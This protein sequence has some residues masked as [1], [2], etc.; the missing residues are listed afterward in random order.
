MNALDECKKFVGKFVR[1]RSDRLT[2]T[3]PSPD[4]INMYAERIVSDRERIPKIRCRYFDRTG[5]YLFFDLSPT[6]LEIIPG[7]PA[8][9]DLGGLSIGDLKKMYVGKKACWK[10]GSPPI[11]ITDFKEDHGGIAVV[12]SWPDTFAFPPLASATF[13]VTMIKVIE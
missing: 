2:A 12:C 1:T 6:V 8:S 4:G 3:I 13:N 5:K 11:T 10:I 7:E 9:N